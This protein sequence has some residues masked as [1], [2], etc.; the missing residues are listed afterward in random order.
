MAQV[1]T[2]IK[3]R[4]TLDGESEE[5]PK[6][7]ISTIRFEKKNSKKDCPKNTK[8]N[9]FTRNKLYNIV[10]V[11]SKFADVHQLQSLQLI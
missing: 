4:V 10:F 2:Y 3:K 9:D 6:E 8:K 1:L 7:L 5:K 11:F